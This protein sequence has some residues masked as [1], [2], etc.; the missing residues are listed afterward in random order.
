MSSFNVNECARAA[1]ITNKKFFGFHCMQRMHASDDIL[2]T[3]CDGK[4]F[5]ISD[6]A[7][8]FQLLGILFY[9]FN[10]NGN[11]VICNYYCRSHE[12]CHD[13]RRTLFAMNW[14]YAYIRFLRFAIAT[15]IIV[16]LQCLVWS[17]NWQ[18]NWIV[19]GSICFHFFSGHFTL[20]HNMLAL[21]WL[22]VEI[23]DYEF[24]LISKRKERWNES[25]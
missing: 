7:S 9:G 8:R 4:E 14:R 22:S 10:C 6:F 24:T 16:G 15:S 13:K 25:E 23:K 11:T 18:K 3:K 5:F 2:W 19:M 20:A 1:Q 21:A 12:L 17:Q